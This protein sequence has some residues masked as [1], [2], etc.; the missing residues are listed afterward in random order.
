MLACCSSMAHP[1]VLNNSSCILCTFASSY[2]RRLQKCTIFTANTVVFVGSLLGFEAKVKV[3][4]TS[5]SA[6]S[7]IY[8][9]SSAA[10]TVLST[11][12]GASKFCPAASLASSASSGNLAGSAPPIGG[13]CS[14]APADEEQPQWGPPA[15]TPTHSS[16]QQQQQRIDRMNARTDHV[17]L[18]ERK[19]CHSVTQSPSPT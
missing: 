6:P 4:A 13:F 16:R 17:Q 2:P 9:T 5:K 19:T 11:Q 10:T 12:G 18:R 7:S 1:V 3:T 8:S 15:P 14:G